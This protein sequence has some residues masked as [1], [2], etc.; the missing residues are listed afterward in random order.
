MEEVELDWSAN[1]YKVV[2]GTIKREYQIR[3]NIIYN[4][5]IDK[6]TKSQDYI[7]E[8]CSVMVA[9]ILGVISASSRN[10]KGEYFK[11]VWDIWF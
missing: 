3:I 7:K 9:K 11:L 10:D 2:I 8:V 1:K 5:K 4:I 6:S